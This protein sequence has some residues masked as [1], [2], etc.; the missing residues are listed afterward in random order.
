VTRRVVQWTTGNVGQRGIIGVLERSDLE[1]V[2]CYVTAAGGKA[3]RDVG[4]LAGVGP[5]GVTAT[6]RLE[7]ILALEPDC[8]VYTPKFNS[9]DELEALLS[10]GINVV[11]TAGFITGHALGNEARSRLLR[12]CEA[13]GSS[14]FGSGMNPGV[15]NLLGIVAGL[16][17]DRVERI[18]VLESVDSTGY[19]SPETEMPAGFGRPMDD[20]ALQELT[21]S[22][23]AVFEDVVW[24]TAEALGIEL[25]E[26]RCE[27]DYAQTTTDLD[28]GSWK[29]DAGCVAGVAASWLGIIDGRTVIDLR[30][31]WRKGATLDPD[32]PIEHG[33][34]VEV[35]GN[36]RVRMRYELLPGPGFH[37]RTPAD[38]MVLG[39]VATVMP[40]INAI[41]AVCDAAPGIVTY[42]D[43]PAHSVRAVVPSA[44]DVPQAR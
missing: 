6:D 32:W 37:G 11:A 12:A 36:P 29:I 17:C 13:G 10:A 9:V 31:Q 35:I 4:E 41:P 28:L 22:A 40:A 19:D 21:R 7:D 18:N 14:M 8:I 42:L 23:T 2:G 33:Y 38:F 39:M 25:D 30:F 27:A 24:L 43:L 1:L 16:V 26:I 34:L 15:A 20:P 3:G 5:I 44:K